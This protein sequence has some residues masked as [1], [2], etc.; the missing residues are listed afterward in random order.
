M[1]VEQSWNRG[2]RHR[3]AVVLLLP[4]FFS[5]G[6]AG[7]VY[8][9]LW[10]RQLQL[11]FGTSTF[12][13]STVLST[14][15]AGLGLGGLLA[16][17][18]A[19]ASRRP[20]RLYGVLEIIIGLYAVAFPLLIAGVAP[21][22]LGVWKLLE[23]GP[24]VFGMIQFV[25]VGTTLLL[26]TVMMGATLPLIVKFAT[27]HLDSAGDRV[28][29]LYALNTAGAVVGTWLAG[30]YLL[31]SLGLWWTTVFAASVNLVLGVAA[32][33]LDSFAGS[34][35]EP[36]TSSSEPVEVPSRLQLVVLVVI[37]LA[38]FASLAYEVAWT[39]LLALLLGAS[40]Y[41][42]SLML[43]AFLVGIAG[44][45]WVG[46]LVADALLRRGGLKGVLLG[47]AAL[48]VGVGG[49][50]FAVMNGIENLPFVYVALYDALTLGDA[51]PGAVW[52]L[53]LVVA[54]LTMTPPALL[55]GA[56]FPLAVRA[57]MNDPESLGRP[58]GRVYGVNTLGGV[59]GAA[60]A[61]FVLLPSIQLEGT[62]LVA[63]LVNL[64]GAI[65][66]L[67]YLARRDALRMSMLAGG[68]AMLGV[69]ATVWLLVPR[70]DAD[71]ERYRLMKTAAMYKYI[72]SFEDHSVEG[73]LDYTVSQYE[74]LYYREGIASVVTVAQNRDPDNPNIWLANNGKIDAST[75]LDMPTQILVGLLPF[76][77]AEAPEDVMVI[78]LASGI[79]VG[80]V[81]TVPAIQRLDVVELEPAT[82]E[83]AVFF[84]DFNNHVLD[85]PR[86]NF[87]FNDGRNQVLLSEEGSYDVIVSEPSNPWISGVSN[88]FTLDFFELG[89]TRLKE[90]G[91]WAQ[92]IQIYGMDPDDLRSLLR[93]FAEVYP[94]VLV[95]MTVDDGDI[96]L[97]GSDRPIAPDAVGA[98]QMLDRWPTVGTEL[99]RIDVDDPFQLLA[100]F[101][102]DRDKILEIAGDIGLNTDDNMRVEYS[103]PLNLYRAT[104]AANSEFLSRHRELPGSVTSPLHLALL[105]ERYLDQFDEQRSLLAFLSGLDGLSDATEVSE[106]LESARRLVEADREYEALGLLT[107][108]VSRLREDGA[109]SEAWLASWD[110]W[111]ERVSDRL[112]YL[113]EVRR[114]DR[115]LDEEDA[116]FLPPQRSQRVEL[117]GGAWT[118]IPGE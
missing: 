60:V 68:V 101:T 98:S 46:G 40:A 67:V 56:S 99:E 50:S 92:W 33:G 116:V 13:I 79:T 30:F 86:V 16:A 26:P 77:Y 93:T 10:A 109:L 61:G 2:A 18:F 25:L 118:T 17:R 31:P 81:A 64:L 59:L 19:D 43:V 20:L 45:G 95:Y 38:G 74:L 88:L 1:G 71:V 70:A 8:Q 82:L 62:V 108:V 113:A 104:T 37:G 6:V 78:G 12:A 100:L 44:G 58:V 115:E 84:E 55:M 28:G 7:L 24:V 112:F 90:G 76:L 41:S 53:S 91:L 14:F 73:V 51:T 97:L 23:P 102:M 96:V 11:V 69:G 48:Q 21:L 89:K 47:L 39:R 3:R 72:T 15:M 75:T 52:T 103:A 34:R 66:L 63:S 106:T 111:L 29:T 114:G 54:G 32:I 5:S 110:R 94:H 87:L 57:V 22:Y 36:V 4:L 9:V 27:T 35:R 80:S 65:S 42:F 85:D 117:E 49:L 83:A 105:G 107:A